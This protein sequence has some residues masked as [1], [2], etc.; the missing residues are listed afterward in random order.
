MVEPIAV[1]T[2]APVAVVAPVVTPADE[3]VVAPVNPGS[4]ETQAS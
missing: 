1:Q 2:F 3:P 4:P